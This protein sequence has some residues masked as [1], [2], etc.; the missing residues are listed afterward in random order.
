MSEKGYHEEVL[1]RMGGV[2]KGYPSHRTDQ[3]WAILGPLLPPPKLGG[4]PR[5]PNLRGVVNGIFYVLRG[6][7]PWPF[8]PKEFPPGRPSITTSACGDGMVLGKC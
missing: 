2:W 8:L 5:A 1:K 7:M 3:E 6:G 4:R